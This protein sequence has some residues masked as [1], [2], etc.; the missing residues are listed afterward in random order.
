LKLVEL[1]Q[2][3]ATSIKR[4]DERRPQAANV[5]TGALYQPGIGPHPESQAVNLIVHELAA[6]APERYASRLHV[7]VAYPGVRQ[8]CD[9]CIG[10]S[11]SWEWAAEVKMLRLMGHNGKPNDNM[12]MHIL[13][14]YQN[15]R[16]ALTDCRKLVES[17]LDGRKAIVIYGFDYAGL[18]MDPAIEAFEVLAARWVTLSARAVHAYSNLVHPIHRAGRVFGWEITRLAA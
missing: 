11:P 1:V 3:I 2:D 17:S 15:D 18:P 13:S 4:I 10:S 16:S 6:L 12:L 8:K 7:G 5:R 14:P 9:L